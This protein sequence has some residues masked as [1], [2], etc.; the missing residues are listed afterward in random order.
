MAYQEAIA[1][2]VRNAIRKATNGG[3]RDTGIW[4][5]VDDAT[6]EIVDLKKGDKQ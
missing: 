6:K 3:T 1:R 2:I 5:I 4:G